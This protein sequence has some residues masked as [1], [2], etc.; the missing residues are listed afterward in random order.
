MCQ[1]LEQL[2]ILDSL[3]DDFA[4]RESL[5]NRAMDIRSAFMLYLAAH[6]QHAVSPFGRI[7]TLNSYILSLH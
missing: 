2:D 3:P 6:I 4:Q 7:G 1:Q 5:V